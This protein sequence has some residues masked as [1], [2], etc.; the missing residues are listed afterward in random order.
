MRRLVEAAAG[1]GIFLPPL[2]ACV[3]PQSQNKPIVGVRFFTPCILRE[4]GQDALTHARDAR[5]TSPWTRRG[6]RSQSVTLAEWV[7][8]EQDRMK[9]YNHDRDDRAEHERTPGRVRRR[10]MLPSTD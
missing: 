1:E 9:Y 10:P 5:V 3:D 2:I 8:A 4:C 6:F 7:A